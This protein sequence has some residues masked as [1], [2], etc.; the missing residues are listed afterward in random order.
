M[1]SRTPPS[2]LEASSLDALERR[3]VYISDALHINHIGKEVLPA[4]NYGCDD[5]SPA[6][7]LKKVQDHNAAYYIYRKGNRLK[8]PTTDRLFDEIIYSSLPGSYLTAAERDAIEQMLVKKFGKNAAVRAAWHI[9]SD[10]R[11][12]LHLLISAK[13]PALEDPEAYE[14]I[15]GQA[16]GN[17]IAAS[18][19]CDRKI[20]K[21]LNANQERK[22]QHTAA[23]DVG[24]DKK[25]S[26]GEKIAKKWP[27]TII[28]AENIG[29]FL[30]KL[31]HTFIE[32]TKKSVTL[33]YNGARSA[34]TRP[35]REILLA[36]GEAQVRL[37]RDK[38]LKAQALEKA[39]VEKTSENKTTQ[40]PNPEYSK[41]KAF[42]EAA[43]GQTIVNPRILME[44][45]KAAKHMLNK[46][47]IIKSVLEKLSDEEK[48][49]LIPL[50]KDY[51]RK[52]IGD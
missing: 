42:F 20:A 4:R 47:G 28:T 26:L 11:A 1:V 10:G 35:L 48:E 9:G 6:A 29:E 39:Q 33:I 19:S 51:N 49:V 14:V 15:F 12:D 45:T 18:I 41:L 32:V 40:N 22:I 43:T 52:K 21:I 25:P 36:I 7:F 24:K 30:T 50:V 2:E 5:Q 16:I 31:G 27:D 46:N 17:S 13:A 38:K 44:R 37:K 8:G 3:T 34:T 23:Y